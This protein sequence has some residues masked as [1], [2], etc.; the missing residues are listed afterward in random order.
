MRFL[1]LALLQFFVLLPLTGYA[2]EAPVARFRGLQK[3]AVMKSYP[4]LPLYFISNDGQT[5]KSVK[6]YEKGAGHSTF[7]TGQGLVLSLFKDKKTEKVRLSFEGADKDLEVMAGRPLETRV[8]YF[9]GN[10]RSKWRRDVPVYGAVLYRG[11]YR[12]VDVRF[13]GNNRKIEHDVIVR[14]G[15]NPADVRFSYD[16]VKSIK[17]TKSGDLEVALSN[18]LIA[19]K[20]PFIYQE[21]D[22]KRVKVEGGYRV[23]NRGRDGHAAYGFNVASYDHTKELV[24]DPVLDYST[25]LGGS[26]ADFG[27]DIAVDNSGAVYITGWT[28]SPDFPTLTPVQGGY[29]GG[30]LTG[31]AFITK[32]NAAGTAVV[33]STFLGG[34]NDEDG[35]SIAVDSTGSAYVTGLTE[36][37]NFPV[38]NAVQ[39][40]FGGGIKDGFVAKLSPAGNALVFSTYLGGTGDDKSKDIAVDSSGA[41][42]ITG[43]TSSLNFPLLN[44]AQA[45]LAGLKDAFVTK[46]NAAGTAFIYSTYLGGTNVDGGRAIAIDSTGAAYVTGHTWSFNFPVVNPIQGVF[47]GL[48]DVVVFKLSPAGNG[49]VF[50][51]YLGGTGTEKSKG[52]ALDSNGAIYITGWTTSLDFP[53]V[54]PLQPV[55][56][57]IQDAF[58]VKLAPPGRRI[59]YS[60]YI[61]GIDS[62]SGRDIAID[63]ADN[64]YMFG[65]T[66]SFDYPVLNPIQGTFGGIRDACLTKI[67]PA[68]TSIIYSTYLGGR[69]NDSGRGIAIDSG[70]V[71][72]LAGGADSVN[73]PVVNP[74]QGASAGLSDV[75]IAR[76][77]Q[78]VGPAVTLSIAPDVNTVAR[79]GSIGYRVTASNNTAARQ[80]FDFW[81]TVTLPNAVIYPPGGALFGPLNVCLNANASKSA[82]LTQAIPLIAPVG[83]YS[84]NTFIGSTYPNVMDPASFNFNV[85]AFSPV[86]GRSNRS[87]RLLEKGFQK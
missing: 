53:L 73:F 4:R 13:Y 56:G 87:W 34:S 67:N 27:R 72:H 16:G 22:G 83:A 42:Y 84:F 78:A 79:G 10:D 45:A 65:H 46:L 21:I 75:F 9:R 39:G 40:A 81:E 38:I 14:A 66:W 24:I 31:D 76:I 68:G 30:V 61:G 12:N 80:C 7:F 2:S 19:Q 5:D 69:G 23:I 59:L 32:I 44:P 35:L 18:G 63:S 8:N 49:L 52:I 1:I 36:S 77:S 71:V 58:V 20:K 41:I 43:W 28:M 54:N 74:I 57:G 60:T 6:F 37:L 86:T 55:F 33:Y 62:D 48:K 17:I 50:S 47:G 26:T 51:T 11:V 70:D 25:Y 3:A 82:H 64:A 85:T 15:G 29:N